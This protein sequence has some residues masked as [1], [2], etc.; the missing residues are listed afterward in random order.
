MAAAAE[1]AVVGAGI[2][3]LSAA[4]ALQE[5]GATVTVYERG[6]PGN[7][8]SGGESRIFRHVHQDPRLIRLARRARAGWREWEE[9]FGCELLSE[10]GVVAI[11]SAVGARLALLEADGEVTARRIDA[12]ELAER[13]PLLARYD[14]PAMLDEGGGAIRTRAAIAA[15]T[16]ALGDRVVSDEVLSVHPRGDGSV[17]LRAAGA[18]REYD[19]VLVCAGRGSAALARGAGLSLPIRQ[20]AH[21]RLSYPV[22]AQPPSRLACLLDS[23]GAFGEPSAYADPLP[24]NRAYAVGVDQTGVNED[25]S[26]IDTGALAEVT[27]RTNAY[28][29]GALPGLE[30]RPFEA[31]HCWVTELPWS[32]DGFALWSVGSLFVFAGNHLFKHAPSLGRA[33]AGA[34]LEGAVPAEL[35][36]EAQLG[37]LTTT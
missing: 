18:M 35:R 10:D 7:G 25:G 23:S 27:E 9:R 16:G 13:L 4:Y 34:A 12:S 19:R 30:P 33:L 20:A 6:A 3:G 5:R 2:I 37:A 14:G 11:G 24:G 28:V 8:Q 31:R 36:P 21:V 22:R 29:A 17:E 26:V 15:L 32:P 1:I